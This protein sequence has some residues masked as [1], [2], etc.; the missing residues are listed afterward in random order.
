MRIYPSPVVLFELLKRVQIGGTGMP[1]RERFRRCEVPSHAHFFHT[2]VLLMPSR[3]IKFLS[4]SML[5]NC[6]A[7]MA[8]D[9][10]PPGGTVV[11]ERRNGVA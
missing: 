3:P 4:L 10:E 9:Q 6:C 5:Q 2:A 1:S 11:P 7:V 8:A